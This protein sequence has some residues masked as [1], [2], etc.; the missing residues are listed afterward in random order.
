MA[1]ICP[2]Q[3]NALGQ[4]Q[5]CDIFTEKEWKDFNYARDLA[6][7]Y[8]SGPGN[9]YGKVMGRPYVEAVIDL[10]KRNAS[11]N[12]DLYFS[13]YEIDESLLTIVHT[14]RI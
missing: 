1:W 6:S 12:H 13:L 5:F 4:S 10:L 2:F 11:I 3:I 8:G 7:Y 9:P 14:T